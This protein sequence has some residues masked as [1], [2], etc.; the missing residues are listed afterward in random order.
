MPSP[1]DQVTLDDNSAFAIFRTYRGNDTT[2]TVGFP[3]DITDYT[4]SGEVVDDIGRHLIDIATQ[5]V[6]SGSPGA[7]VYEVNNTITAAQNETLNH[8][9][10]FR[11]TWVQSGLYHRTY[12]SGPVEINDK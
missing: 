7:Y 5:K 1:L 10:V 3:F 8:G 6:I 12:I 9:D 11:L 4:F 2:F